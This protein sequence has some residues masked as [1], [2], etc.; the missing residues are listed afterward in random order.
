LPGNLVAP[1][2]SGS[3]LTALTAALMALAAF[4][5]AHAETGNA[6]ELRAQ[7][8]RAHRELRTLEARIG[9]LDSG[10]DQGGHLAVVD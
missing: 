3:L 6:A 8:R 5:T 4:V 10:P 9:V 2:L 1:V 7:L